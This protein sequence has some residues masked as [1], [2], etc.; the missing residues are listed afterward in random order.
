MSKII[1]IN[2]NWVEAGSHGALARGSSRPYRLLARSLGIHPGE[3]RSILPRDTKILCRGSIPRTVAKIKSSQREI[4]WFRSNVTEL[5]AGCDPLGGR[6][7]NEASNTLGQEPS[8]GR[9]HEPAAECS[10]PSCHQ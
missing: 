2:Q 9:C 5:G 1:S 10:E 8:G 7:R 3:G 4:R 6:Q